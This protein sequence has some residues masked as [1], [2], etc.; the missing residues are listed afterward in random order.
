MIFAKLDFDQ[1]EKDTYRRGR[2]AG[3]EQTPEFAYAPSLEVNTVVQ[4]SQVA[5]RKSQV[6]SNTHD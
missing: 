6:A 5:S 4:K 2:D 3:K 1:K